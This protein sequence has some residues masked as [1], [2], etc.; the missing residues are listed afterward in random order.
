[1]RDPARE[2]TCD[3]LTVEGLTVTFPSKRGPVAAVE[4]VSFSVGAGQTV[5]LVGE[6]GSGKTVSAL[7]VLGLTHA[8]G[9]EATGKVIFE[10]R[11]L[12]GLSE[13]QLAKVR[14]LRI[15]M[16]FQQPVRSLDPAFS[17]GE[18]IAE[19]I[20]RHLKMSRRAAWRRAVDMLDRVGIA[21]A[22]QRA[23]E[24]P[25]TFSGGMC[26][27]VMIAM[28]LSC[29]PSLLIADEP[30]TALDVTVQARILELLRDIQAETG[31]AILFIS[32][33]LGVIAEMCQSVV[34]MYA[35]EVVERASV[36]DLF[37]RPRHPYTGGLLA[38]VPKVGM[39]RE[40]VA[41]P[42]NV[43]AP[44][45]YPAGCRFHPR[46]PHAEA[47]RCDTAEPTLRIDTAGRSVRC[48]RADELALDG[49][50]VR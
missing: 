21:N 7:A 1:M 43:P 49:V 27:R 47:G 39:R 26:Q 25:H 30:T 50:L 3:L 5:G 11:D 13:G 16:I 18:Q 48:V 29:S 32:H 6:S 8:Q 20:R 37:V 19:T 12:T 24:Y 2:S 34:V 17:V 22:A 46:C 9:G 28:A 14:G 42:G 36:E 38:A 33:D 44:G 41:I 15:G 4:D 31:I 23:H 35:G 40:L 45:H 10:G